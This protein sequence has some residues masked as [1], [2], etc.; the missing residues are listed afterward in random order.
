MTRLYIL[1]A[2]L[3]LMLGATACDSNGV[4]SD[5]GYQVTYTVTTTGE[6]TI[7]ALSYR[8]ARGALV[9]VANPALP[10]TRHVAMRP[11]DQAW[12]SVDGTALSGTFAVALQAVNDD[13]V[14]T[15]NTACV[16][17]TDEVYPKTCDDLSVESRL[18]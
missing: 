3:L 18:P 4:S 10:W 9:T 2:L 6:N 11:G 14:I 7:T 5:S 12:I 8:D 13:N 17:G 16:T 15:L 1:P